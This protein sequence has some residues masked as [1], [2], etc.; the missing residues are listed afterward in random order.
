MKKQIPLIAGFVLAT[1]I[2]AQAQNQLGNQLQ[3]GKALPPITE[4][5]ATTVGV[6]DGITVTAGTQL[7]T[8]QQGSVLYIL[9]DSTLHKYEL[10]AKSLKGSALVKGDLAKALKSGVVKAA[11]DVPVT[12]LKSKETGLDDNAYKA[13][14]AKDNPDILFSLKS[15]KVTGDSA[16]LKGDL[17]IS[18]VTQPV[19]LSAKAKVTDRSVELSGVQKLKMTDFQI[20][21][22]S[23]SLVVTSITCTDEIEVHYD[24]TFASVKEEA[25]H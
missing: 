21:P 9:G 14:K 2:T 3:S 8:L 15:V 19:T 18:G 5:P 22:P 16:T 20:T 6:V 25:A 7:Y 4:R 1:A 23:V 12:S 17:T 13:L 24:V 11:L 10:G